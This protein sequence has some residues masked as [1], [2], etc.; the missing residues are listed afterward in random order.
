MNPKA[1]KITT[2]VMALTAVAIWIPQLM[3]GVVQKPS[4]PRPE[5][6]AE[7][8]AESDDAFDSGYDA[9]LEDDVADEFAT[10]LE[11][12]SERPASGSLAEQLEQTTERLRVFGGPRRVDLDQL[13]ANFRTPASAE[14][15]Q[16][17]PDTPSSAAAAASRNALSQQLAEDALDDF[18]AAQSLTAIIHGQSGT[19]A[20]LGDQ[21]VRIGDELAPGI[22]VTEI[23]PRR[24]RIAGGGNARWL[25]L[26][27]FRTRAASEDDQGETTDSTQNGPVS[28]PELRYLAPNDVLSAPIATQPVLDETT[29]STDREE[30]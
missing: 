29:R 12:V 28:T 6:D 19:L 14:T 22:A 21:L 20:M 17:S 30:D 9:A 10:D 8:S 26:A 4:T 18:A 7:L 13:L 25:Q 2:S 24:V 16:E 27:P 11:E 15:V 5:F 3:T 1:K 23:E